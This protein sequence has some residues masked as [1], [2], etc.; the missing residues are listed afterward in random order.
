M[1]SALVLLLA[2]SAAP[3][4]AT[5]LAERS[6]REYRAGQFQAAL[7][8]AERA[9]ALLPAPT[10]LFNEGL[11]FRALRR[12]ADARTAFELYVAAAPR[13][14]NRAQAAALVAEMEKRLAAERAAAPPEAPPVVLAGRPA[15]AAVGAAQPP[16]RARAIEAY[17]DPVLAEELSRP[18][19]QHQTG[20]TVV[21]AGLV[22]IG[23]L[24]I[25]AGTVFGILSSQLLSADL[26]KPGVD[27][28]TLHSRSYANLGRGDSFGI[29]ADACFA[30]G[31][32]LVVAGI[33]WALATGGSPP[34]PGPTV[35]PPVLSWAF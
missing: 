10:L 4:D 24:A 6:M 22:T 18:A 21:V 16:T 8:D 34:P 25:G 17:G 3:A 28:T 1:I 2:A 19:P 20:R 26:Q 13:A 9:Y 12:W 7:A 30:G 23:T 5:A 14:S 32:A 31:A 35:S 15:A 11:C 33:V 27:G 29:A